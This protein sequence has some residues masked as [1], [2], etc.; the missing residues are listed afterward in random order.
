MNDSKRSLTVG[1]L[2]ELARLSANAHE[3]M[4]IYA[5]IDRLVQAVIGHRL[6]TLM[7]VHEASSQVERIYSSNTAAYP[8]GGR[9]D[10]RGTPWSRVVLD[11]GEVFIARNP[12][13]VREAFS[14]HALIASLSIGSIMNIPIAYRGR[15]LGTMNI[16]HQAGWFTE[17]HA[18]AGCLIAAFAAPPLLSD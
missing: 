9:K 10:K 12:E 17:E 14:D 7:R 1:D 6:F 15:R 8:V 13:E 4:Q 5:A 16:S 3:P 2:A 11:R 18:S